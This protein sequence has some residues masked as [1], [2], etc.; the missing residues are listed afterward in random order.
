MNCGLL[1]KERLPAIQS[2]S[3]KL[4]QKDQLR[5]WAANRTRCWSLLCQLYL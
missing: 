5:P 2:V 1:L 3:L 4:P